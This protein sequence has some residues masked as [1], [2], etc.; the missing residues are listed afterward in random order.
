M[1]SQFYYI[2]IINIIFIKTQNYND[3]SW[4]VFFA[5]LD[6][7]MCVLYTYVFCHFF[8]SFFDN[9][10]FRRKKSEMSSVFFLMWPMLFTTPS[11]SSEGSFLNPWNN[12]KL[13]QN[14]WKWKKKWC[15]CSLG[16]K[17]A[18]LDLKHCT[19][20]ELER[21]P[22]TRIGPGEWTDDLILVKAS[23]G[24]IDPHQIWA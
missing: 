14:P 11:T 15:N 22:R 17:K 10:R 3:P 1:L 19:Y 20:L 18:C 13:Q 23:S 4:R 9:N 12:D 8:L 24:L 16:W 6:I 2:I 7:I 21:G 5:L